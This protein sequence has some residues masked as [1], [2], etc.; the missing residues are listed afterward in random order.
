MTQASVTGR[1]APAGRVIEDSVEIAAP[2]D[3]VWKALTDAEELTRWFPLDARVTPGPGGSIW[4]SWRN[5]YQ[6]ETS[7]EIWDPPHRLRLASA[8]P[9]PAAS[10]PGSAATGSSRPKRTPTSGAEARASIAGDLADPSFMSA[11]AVQ[12]AIDYQLEARGGT[13]LLRLVHSG[14]GPG[15]EWDTE[16]DATRRGWAF[17]LGALRHYLERHRGS[18]RDVVYERVKIDVPREEAWERLMGPDGLRASGLARLN[19][20]ARYSLTMATGDVFEGKVLSLEAPKG[21]EATAE[22]LNGALLRLTLDDLP[23][24][25]VRDVTVWITTYGLPR[26]QVAGLRARWKELLRR[27]YPGAEEAGA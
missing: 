24:R 8:P 13:T 5:E 11:D 16:L 15:A 23:L 22:N 27:L 19:P 26:D 2:I 10:E 3:A 6:W 18:T 7:I 25:K 9:P 1:S 21:F 20:G 17:E 4:M 12:I 14:F